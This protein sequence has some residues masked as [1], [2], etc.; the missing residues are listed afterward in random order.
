M[1]TYLHIEVL[2]FI[3]ILKEGFKIHWHF[4]SGMVWLENLGE[5]VKKEI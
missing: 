3:N 5:A 1:A 4:L 2:V